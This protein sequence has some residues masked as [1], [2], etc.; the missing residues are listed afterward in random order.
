MRCMY[1]QS[2]VAQI[3]GLRDAPPSTPSQRV[4][5]RG[6][7]GGGR[8]A[9]LS[10]P[11][12]VAGSRAAPGPSAKRTAAK[13]R[14]A[15]ADF[16]S[17]VRGTPVCASRDKYELATTTMK[18]GDLIASAAD[19][20]MGL[21]L[22]RAERST[23]YFPAGK[24]RSKR[25]CALSSAGCRDHVCGCSCFGLARA[26]ALLCLGCSSLVNPMHVEGCA[27]RIVAV[28]SPVR[29]DH[30]RGRFVHASLDDRALLPP[31]VDCARVRD[32]EQRIAVAK[33]RGRRA[34]RSPPFRVLVAPQK[35]R[36]IDRCYWQRRSVVARSTIGATLGQTHA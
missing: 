33:R 3:P 22:P 12:A 16:A 20:W 31:R 19:R 9:E 24:A 11:P 7:G 14:R 32:I 5:R 2:S 6:G 1:V 30:G 21:S 36:R 15:F 13:T 18:G 27:P 26:I 34:C 28:V 35:P 17:F 8:S 4:Q 29:R 25:P 10:L 23:T